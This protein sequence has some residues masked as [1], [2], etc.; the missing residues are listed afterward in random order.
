[1]NEEELELPVHKR[2]V[3][4]SQYLL[5]VFYKNRLHARE[6]GSHKVCIAG[7]T[8]TEATDVQSLLQVRP[9]TMKGLVMTIW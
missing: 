2:G 3:T 1:M 7:L 9:E 8:E 4:T 5:W 6:D